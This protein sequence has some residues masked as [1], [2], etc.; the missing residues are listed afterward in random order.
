MCT[1]VRI[2]RICCWLGPL[3]G[4]AAALRGAR[5]SAQHVQTLCRVSPPASGGAPPIGIWTA[6]GNGRGFSFEGDG[7]S[8]IQSQVECAGPAP[9]CTPL[10]AA[11]FEVAEVSKC[12]ACPC[13]ANAT[14]LSSL[15]ASTQHMFAEIERVCRTAGPQKTVDILMLGLGGGALHTYT[16]NHCP[17]ETRVRSVEI[18]S[19]VAAVASRYFGLPL[20]QGT[21]EVVVDEGGRVAGREASLARARAGSPTAEGAAST[22]GSRGW[23][24]IVVDAFIGNGRTPESCRSAQFIRHLREALRPAA[25]SRVLHHLWHSSPQAPQVAGEYQAAVADYRSVFGEAAVEVL[26][27][28]RHPMVDDLIV[29]GPARGS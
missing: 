7:D 24:V 1:R 8:N 3:L 13:N 11:E 16:M 10:P 19:R 23:D 17:P 5:V 2:Y 4:Q 14:A 9:S 6:P 26:P 28:Q 29:A 18:D 25:S 12:P 15:L 27:V 20:R 22:L 21:S